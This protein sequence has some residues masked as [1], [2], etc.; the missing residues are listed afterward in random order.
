MWN[1]TMFVDLDWPLNASSLLSAS[2]E[3]LVLKSCTEFGMMT[4][5][6]EGK[7]FASNALPSAP[8]CKYCSVPHACSNSLTKKF[9]A[10]IHLIDR[11]RRCLVSELVHSTGV[12]KS[13]LG[14]YRN[15]AVYQQNGDRCIIYRADFVWMIAIQLFYGFY[16][17][18]AK[19]EIVYCLELDW[20]QP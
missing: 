19:N 17:N 13:G 14:S 5:Y 20:L 9:D 16:D 15:D 12:G 3:L 4:Q 8:G 1:G 18:T 10:I 6:E 11:L 2:A 7:R